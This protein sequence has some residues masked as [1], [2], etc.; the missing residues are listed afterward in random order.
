M[1]RLKQSQ[2]HLSS[3]GP[4]PILKLKVSVACFLLQESKWFDLKVTELLSH[5]DDVFFF[6]FYNSFNLA[7]CS[8][9]E[10]QKQDRTALLKEVAE[11][12]HFG[13]E[14]QEN[15]KKS[16]YTTA[17]NAKSVLK[18]KSYNLLIF[19]AKTSAVISQGVS[20]LTYVTA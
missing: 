12:S 20:S 19:W 1:H 17:A 6:R 5:F 8:R 10:G 18:S 7:V 9:L 2:W 13:L 14:I 4:S 16:L 15:K 11:I 3:G